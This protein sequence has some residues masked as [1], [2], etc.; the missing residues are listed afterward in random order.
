MWRKLLVA[1]DWTAVGG[2]PYIYNYLYIFIH[3]VS[4]TWQFFLE[5]YISTSNFYKSMYI[6][7]Y[8]MFICILS[9]ICMDFWPDSKNIQPLQLQTLRF[10][11]ISK[12]FDAR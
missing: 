12:P 2:E 1:A 9:T 11:W 7:I 6:Y 5:A 4:L 8:F 10:N 3:T